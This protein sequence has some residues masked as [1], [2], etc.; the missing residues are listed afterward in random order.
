[1]PTDPSYR[2][3]NIHSLDICSQE[4]FATRNGP[5]NRSPLPINFDLTP[6]I[7]F[8]TFDVMPPT[9]KTTEEENIQNGIDYRITLEIGG[10]EYNSL[11]TM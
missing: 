10:K 8:N 9:Q 2:K 4:Y 5:T 3:E 11:S 6:P 1:M 7:D